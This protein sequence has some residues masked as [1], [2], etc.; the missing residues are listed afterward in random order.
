[1]MKLIA[2]PEFR[3]QLTTRNLVVLSA[4]MVVLVFLLQGNTGFNVPDEGFLWYGTIRTAIGEIP[5]R[6]FQSY[7]PGRYY[8]GALWFKLLGN[9]GILALRVSQAALQFIGLTLALLLM[10]RLVNSW[11][12]L[13]FAAIILL[14][15]MVPTWK[16][17]EPVIV[18]A[19]IYFAVLI[20]EQPSVRRHLLAGTFAGLAGFFGRNH[21]LYCCVAFFL[22]AVFISWKSEKL[23]LVRRLSALA[24]GVMVG[25][26][27][28]LVMLGLVPGF[29]S[30]FKEDL[31]FNLHSATNLPLPVPW[32]WR[33]S[34][35]LVGVREAINR[36]TIGVLYLAFPA[37]Y[38]FGFAHLFFKRKVRPHPVFIASVF[39]GV[40][41]LHY[42]FARPQLYYLAWTIPPLILG[43]L[44]VPASFSKQRSKTV[45]ITIWV[46][47]AGFTIGALELSQ[48]NYFTV[49]A[50]AFAKAKLLRRYDGDFERAMN[51]QALVKTDI[52]GDKLWVSTDAAKLINSVEDINRD[53]IQRSDG[54]L[55][56]PYFP[57][58]YAVLQKRSPLW[59]IYFLL[60][61]S[62][63]DQERMVRD[64][65][66]QG[67]DWALIC[68][69]YVDGRRELQFKNTHGLVW[70]YL[71][72]NF[73]TIRTEET[74]PLGPDCELMHRI[75]R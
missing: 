61:R 36:L 4:V 10:R 17:Y 65:E 12:A 46:V 11:I 40:M 75:S 53:L 59:E 69:S 64:L 3:P 5:V 16:I 32:P 7:E 38:I 26:L 30:H 50:K 2:W 35:R 22:L 8:W 13:I 9:D 43:L 47:L 60:P 14:R 34:Y 63:K 33:Q 37:F 24:L 74:S 62:L 68:H 44:A 72:A 31:L 66:G 41:Y 56:A 23:V 42:T 58:L 52:R 29:F 19:A 28:M 54:L 51:A 1:M 27:P 39:V 18:I 45:A 57:G 48:D 49:K 67:V 15:W 73:E 20:L 25:Y 55:A 70:Q 21:G 6:D 71:V